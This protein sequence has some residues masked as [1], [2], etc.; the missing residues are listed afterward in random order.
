MLCHEVGAVDDAWMD[1]VAQIVGGALD[2]VEGA[3][4][5]VRQE[6][7]DVLQQKS[8][9]LLGFNEAANVEEERALRFVDK[10]VGAAECVFLGNTG[11]RERLAGGRVTAKAV[12]R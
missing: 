1:V 9:W 2:N 11:N 10:V 6:I 3:P 12:R 5:V 7:L 8:A 4:L